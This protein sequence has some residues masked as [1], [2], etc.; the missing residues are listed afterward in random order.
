[1]KAF[2]NNQSYNVVHVGENIVVVLDPSIEGEDQ[3]KV[4]MKNEVHLGVSPTKPKK[5][6]RKRMA[7]HQLIFSNSPLNPMK[8]I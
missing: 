8:A 1:M 2:H 4:L 3:R 6:K 7:S 5:K